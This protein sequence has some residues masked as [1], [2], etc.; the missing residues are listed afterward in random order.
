MWELFWMGQLMLFVHMSIC[1]LVWRMR[2]QWFLSL[3]EWFLT[4]PS[5]SALC[6]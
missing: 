3:E 1:V 2:V 6:E 5:F 4:I